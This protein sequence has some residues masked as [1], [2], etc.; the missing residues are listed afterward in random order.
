MR[1]RPPPPPLLLSEPY[2]PKDGNLYFGNL[3]SALNNLVPARATLAAELAA[4]APLS[5]AAAK[6]SFRE[7]T[8][9]DAPP[10]LAACRAADDLCYASA[11]YAEGIRAFGEKRRPVFDGR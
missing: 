4:N 1:P 5:L 3:R 8:R 6:Q 11:D 2:G 7:L 9:R 10:D